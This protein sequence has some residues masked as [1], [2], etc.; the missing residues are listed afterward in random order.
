M[1]TPKKAKELLPKHL[2]DLQK[3]GL[4]V[5][6]A[7]TLLMESTEPGKLK[8]PYFDQNGKVTDFF[9]TKLF[10]TE[11]QLAKR[12]KEP[13]KYVQS[14]GT[15]PEIYLPPLLPAKW[16]AVLSDPG[17]EI[18]VTEGEKKAAKLCSEGIACIGLG[19]TNSWRSRK[20]ATA[21]LAALETAT[22]KDRVVRV[23]GDS[24]LPGKESARKGLVQFT[25]Q[26]C[27][28]GAKAT[29]F[30]VPDDGTGEKIGVDDFIVKHGM[31]S[32]MALLLDPTKTIGDPGL[33]KLNSQLAVIRATG[34][35]VALETGRV[36]GNQAAGNVFGKYG[37]LKA[38]IEWPRRNEVDKLV[39]DPKAPR[40]MTPS[41]DYNTFP[42]WAV[43]PQKCAAKEVAKW[44]DLLR[45][46][47]PDATDAEL[48]WVECWFGYP[49]KHPGT[50]LN[51]ALL[52]WS[53][54]QGSGKTT[55][56]TPMKRI[57][58]PL[59][60]KVDG[61]KLSG[62]F[63]EW[64]VD[65]QF[66]LGEELQMGSKRA[67]KDMLKDM[68]T[69]ETLTV[70]IKNRRTYDVVDY[71]N[72][73]FTSNHPDAMYIEASDRRIAVFHASETVMSTDYRRELDK[74]LDE[75]GAAKMRYYFESILNYDGFDPYD[76]P[77]VTAAKLEMAAATRTD[78]EDWIVELLANPDLMLPRHYELWTT[79]DLFRLYDPD[80]RGDLKAR[81]F[82]TKLGIAKVPH[83]SENNNAV[84]GGSRS[85]LWVIRGDARKYR[86]MTA[87]QLTA[88]YDA[89]RAQHD[90]ARK[91]A[92]KRKEAKP[93]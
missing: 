63:N 72:Y 35:F 85:R 26:L 39:F 59:W 13:P 48:Y 80:K 12:K 81:G 32:F 68:I 62:Q 2:E 84:I 86:Q 82:A 20:L 69:G 44:R 87:T 47:L 45:K 88:A 17:V 53:D 42:G 56:A 74:W 18:V 4:T 19:G 22:W 58:G 49:I 16:S 27:K 3:S 70:N 14:R 76:R 50:K 91:F 36:Y 30:F 65:R 31:E 43:E 23:I 41:G 93:N 24:D 92:E 54:A 28:R 61:T 1:A 79:D 77:P 83:A 90:P 57:Y 46:V 66:I 33:E 89:E 60:G 7:Q 9:R 55:L 75:G 52:V 8:L 29:H 11:A 40:G 51:S 34:E 6:H 38:W 78:A 71:L 10:Y 67:L 21:F 73:M 5:E 37:D 64:A 15:A 25:E